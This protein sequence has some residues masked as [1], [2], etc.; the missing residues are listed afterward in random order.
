MKK[1]RSRRSRIIVIGLLL[2]LI[3]WIIWTNINI[4]TTQLTITNQKIPA[5][6]EGYKIAQVSDLHNRRWGNKLTDRLRDEQPDIIVITGDLV[7][8]RHTD[9]D[10]AMEFID[11]AKEIAPI[12]YV[13]GNHEARLSNYKELAQRLADAGVHMMDDTAEQIEKGSA[14]ITLAGLQDPEFV[15]RDPDKGLRESI[16]ATKLGSLLTGDDYHIV[17]SHRPE[18]IGGY[19]EAGADL[20]FTGHAHGGQVRIPLVGGLI[21]PN[22]GFFPEYTEGVY[23]EGPLDMVVSRGLGNSVIPVRINNMPELVIVT[24][25]HS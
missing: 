8:S 22:Q 7:D 13:T 10:A 6:F 19:A 25:A 9:F 17:L 23:S 16:A 3:S 20:V 12:Y 5:E 1:R 4:T 18:L 11:G 21:A 2:L 24:L 14:K 15:E